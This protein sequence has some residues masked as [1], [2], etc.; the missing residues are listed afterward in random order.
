MQIILYSAYRVEDIDPEKLETEVWQPW[1]THAD[2]IAK[3]TKGGK[4]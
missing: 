1:E 4:L 2:Y 3:I